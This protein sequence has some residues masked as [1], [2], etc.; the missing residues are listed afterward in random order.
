MVTDE[1]D[2]IFNNMSN[3]LVLVTD[4]MVHVGLTKCCSFWQPC[5]SPSADLLG[6]PEP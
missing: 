3:I 6:D 4:K 5:F 1:K 2:R